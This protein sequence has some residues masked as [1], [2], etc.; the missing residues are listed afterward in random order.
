MNRRDVLMGGALLTAAGAALALQP[1]ERLVLL[2]DRQL[3][4]IIP[5]KIGDWHY[6]KSSDF[7]LPKSP[8]SLADRLYSQLLTRLYLSDNNLPMI[9]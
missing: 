5:S 9:V 8:G 7:V 1:R 6:V 3:D 4:D 2:G